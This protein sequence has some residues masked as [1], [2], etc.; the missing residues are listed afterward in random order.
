MGHIVITADRKNTLPVLFEGLRKP[1]YLGC[2]SENIIC[3]CNW[4][5]A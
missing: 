4:R 2:Y 1:E 3:I 5:A